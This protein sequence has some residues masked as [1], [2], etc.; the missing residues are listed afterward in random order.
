MQQ[1]RKHT[2]E[3]N[4]WLIDNIE[5]YHSYDEM[6]KDYNKL[7]NRNYKNGGC[8]AKYCKTYLGLKKVNR[9]LWGINIPV[10]NENEKYKIGDIIKRANGYFIKLGKDNFYEYGRYLYEQK[11]GKIPSED[12]VI[13]LDG[14]R[15][16]NDME[17]LYH[18][19]KRITAAMS[20]LNFY[21][22]GKLTI[23]G[24]KYCELIN[25]LRG[26]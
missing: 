25:I 18:I 10:Y 2:Q 4:Q 3:E 11:F 24:A 20:K 21:N 13:H 7:F 14:D 12:F 16:N 15:F 26:D 8:L 9:H 23:A 1:N 5:N 19:P 22:K 17:N 6:V